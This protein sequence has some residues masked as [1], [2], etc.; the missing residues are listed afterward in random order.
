MPTT[1]NDPSPWQVPRWKR[2]AGVMSFGAVVLAGSLVLSMFGLEQDVPR[3]VG[4]VSMLGAVIGG[5]VLVVLYMIAAF[6]WGRGVASRVAGESASRGVVQLGVGLSGLLWISHLLAMFGL[7]SDGGPLAGTIAGPR[8]IGW[9]VIVVG[10]AIVAHQVV[11]GPLRPERWPVFPIGA[12]VW[13]PALAVMLVAAANP[14]GSLWGS[15]FGGYDALSYHL[16]LPKEWA[17]GERLWPAEH[18]VYSYLPSYVESA[19][20]HLGAMSFEPGAAVQRMVGGESAWV[21]S[22]QLLHAAIGVVAALLVA[23]LVSML[24]ERSGVDPRLGRWSGLAA[25]AVMIGT[26]WTVVVGTLAYNDLAVVAMLA[27]SLLVA[28]DGKTRPTGRAVAVGW[29]MGIACS[30]K[31]TA[32]F[33]AAPAAGLAL[34]YGL[35]R[36]RWIGAV[37][38]GSIAGLMA[39]APWLIRNALASGGNPVFPFLSTV[40]GSGHWSAE[41]VA[42]YT[43]AHFFDGSIADRVRLL[44][45]ERGLGHGQWAMSPLIGVAGLGV[46]LVQRAHRS[47]GVVLLLGVLAQLCA[48]L[49]LSHLQSRFLLPLIVPCAVA[50][51]LGASVLLSRMSGLASGGRVEAT[52]GGGFAVR[53]ALVLLMIAPVGLAGWSVVTFIQ[54]LG[55]RPNRLLVAGVSGL[56]GAAFKPRLAEFSPAERSGF[57]SGAPSPTVYFNL[58]FVGGERRSEVVGA[59]GSARAEAVYLLGDATP[60]YMLGAVGGARSDGGEGLSPIVY[61][62]AW[63]ASPL[64]DAIRARPDD[65]RSWSAELAKRGIGRVLVNAPELHRLIERSR[66]YDADVTI[67][68]VGR[69]LSD[70]DS[71]LRSVRTWPGGYELFEIVEGA[72]R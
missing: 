59:G 41:Q 50:F 64:G 36:R 2:S 30:A 29:M 4:P 38:A 48:W 23:R 19:F 60:L 6:G 3:V 51:G 71:G 37:V 24:A 26:P 65:P 10:L 42:R 57:L 28:F 33:M 22:A 69:W 39:M 49:F 55:G 17:A 12:V 54:Q 63:D 20:V 32:L 5:G 11:G 40:F 43:Q 44:V 21:H 15:E 27:A 1:A 46:A 18:N 31:P 13:A 14:P 62:T 45:G 52:R 70:R 35:P 56:T 72:G 53:S 34:L 9:L 47:V 16:Q 25:G 66:Y 7:M 8:L 61:H 68:R 67:E 58:E